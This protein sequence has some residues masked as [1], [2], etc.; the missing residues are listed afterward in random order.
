MRALAVLLS[1]LPWAPKLSAEENRHILASVLVLEAGN[2]GYVGMY[3]VASVIRNRAIQ[4]K[5]TFTHQV[6]RPS[7]FSCLNHRSAYGA[8]QVARAR[9]DQW[10]T[11]MNVI[12]RILSDDVWWDNTLGATHYEHRR[13]VPYWARGMKVTTRIKNHVFYK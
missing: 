13:H 9:T 1:F 3:A 8:I 2:E 12:D 11:A 5:T 6:L 10:N 7:Q 4:H